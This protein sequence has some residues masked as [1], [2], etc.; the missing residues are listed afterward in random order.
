MKKHNNPNKNII[1]LKPLLIF[2]CYQRLGRVQQ[3][4]LQSVQNFN[5]VILHVGE[6]TPQNNRADN[7]SGVH[8]VTKS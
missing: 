7:V 3:Q 1:G 2:C 6:I 4:H 8:I 5:K